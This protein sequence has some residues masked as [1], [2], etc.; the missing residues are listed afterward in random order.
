MD[1]QKHLPRTTVI[2]LRQRWAAGFTVAELS[3]L[4]GVSVQSVSA[5]V[6]GH[7][8]RRV[9]PLP[10]ERLLP[11]ANRQERSTRDPNRTRPTAL[12]LA[13]MITPKR[14]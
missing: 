2:A 14:R 7:T 3:R 10:G 5:I 13:R 6:N 8:H 11:L 1:K 9:K 12:E 4:S